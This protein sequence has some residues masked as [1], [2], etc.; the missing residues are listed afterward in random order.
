MRNQLYGKDH[1][2]MRFITST[3]RQTRTG[4]RRAALAAAS[5]IFAATGGQ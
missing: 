1:P 5:A 3:V 2:N 4:A